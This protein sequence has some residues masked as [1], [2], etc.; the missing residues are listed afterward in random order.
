MK[1]ILIVDDEDS[2]RKSLAGQLKLKGFGVV[3]ACD[4]L[5][6]VEMAAKFKPDVI[7]SDVEDDIRG[8]TFQDL[9]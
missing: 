2:F 4:G 6:G 8:W 5:E 9:I 1:K 3:E 7:L